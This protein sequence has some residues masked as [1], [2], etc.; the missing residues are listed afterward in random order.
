MGRLAGRQSDRKE[1]P[2]MPAATGGWDVAQSI[3]LLIWKLLNFTSSKTPAR[4]TVSNNVK[5][6]HFK[7]LL[8]TDFFIY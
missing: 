3:G 6:T 8:N 4:V 7:L 5:A 1:K 2:R